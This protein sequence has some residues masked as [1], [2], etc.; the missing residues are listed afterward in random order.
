MS[1]RFLKSDFEELNRL[2]IS[3]NVSDTYGAELYWLHVIDYADSQFMQS[4]M[5]HHHDFFEI[6]FILSGNMV[7]STPLGN[8]PVSEGSY[9]IFPPGVSHGVEYYSPDMLKYSLSLRLSESNIFEDILTQKSSV[10]QTSNEDITDL[11]RFTA[12][13]ANKKLLHAD[14]LIKNRIFELLSLICSEASQKKLRLVAPPTIGGE[15]LRVFKAKLFIRDN[16]NIFIGCAELAAYC[17]VS[18]KQLN[19]LFLRYEG[20]SLLAYLHKEKV[21][22]AKKMLLEGKNVKT[23]SETLGFSSVYYFS[24][25]FK[26]HTGMTCEEFRQS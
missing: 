20:I 25:F 19:R 7:Y 14:T 26:R 3:G 2:F 24:R 12:H 13:A 11:I 4:A 23:V 15:D 9:I 22:L 10:S 16:P 21:L 17:S 6:H 5:M 1:R 8:V 18:A